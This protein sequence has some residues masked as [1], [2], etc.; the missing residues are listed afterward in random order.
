M[1]EIVRCPGEVNYFRDYKR[2]E[3]FAKLATSYE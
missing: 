1:G 2:L 3:H